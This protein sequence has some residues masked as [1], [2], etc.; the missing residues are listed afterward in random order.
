MVKKAMRST[1]T[2]RFVCAYSGS[3]TW[4]SARHGHSAAASCSP[5]KNT[6]ACP[7]MN[8]PWKT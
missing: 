1:L 8:S 5:A 2:P 4:Y 7:V 3:V 6:N